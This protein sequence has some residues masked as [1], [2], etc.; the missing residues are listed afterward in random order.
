MRR[1]NASH[2]FDRKLWQQDIRQSRAHAE[3][4]KGR[5]LI[6]ASDHQ[7]IVEGLTQVE[8]EIASGAFSWSDE[9]EDIHMHVEHR[10]TE[11]LRTG[12]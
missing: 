4:L 10:L 9:L 5:G 1:I 2:P 6:S 8:T 11:N 7:A 12:R 3:M